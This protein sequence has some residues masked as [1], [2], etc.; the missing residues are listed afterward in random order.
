MTDTGQKLDL[1]TDW[2]KA[3][4]VTIH[5]NSTVVTIKGVND[6]GSAG[7]ILASFSNG[8]VTDVTWQCAEIGNATECENSI[9]W[10][11]AQTYGVNG[12]NQSIW[13]KVRSG[14][15]EEIESTAQW[16]WVNYHSATNV[17]CKKTFGKS[18]KM[19]CER[20]LV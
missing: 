2:Q 13:G 11:D 7:G 14:P 5:G 12:D 10:E 8:V 18:H 17:C 1:N 6:P 4:R 15:F 19:I 20:Q 3:D 9:T 16:I